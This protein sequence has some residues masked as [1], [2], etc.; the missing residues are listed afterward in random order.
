MSCSSQVGDHLPCSARARMRDI[1]S[2]LGR[3]NTEMFEVVDPKILFLPCVYSSLYIAANSYR[4]EHRRSVGLFT[5][6]I[7][8][9]VLCGTICCSSSDS[10]WMILHLDSQLKS[11]RGI[12]LCEI[13]AQK[14]QVRPIISHSSQRT[15]H[16][17]TIHPKR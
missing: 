9:T 12:S 4:R 6:S 2:K 17:T 8:Y 1:R 7:L 13:V 5:A 11:C 15:S 10:R 16:T 14:V 3:T